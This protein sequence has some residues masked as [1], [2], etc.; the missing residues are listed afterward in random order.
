MHYQFVR[1]L[2]QQLLDLNLDVV[3]LII[4]LATFVRHDG[5]G[6]HGTR[7]S[8]RTTKS[9]LGRNKHVGNILILAEEGDMEND[10]EGLRIGSHHD[11]RSLSTVQGLRS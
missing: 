3:D 7:H 4:Q 6:D 5:A 2:N 11:K 8:T 9:N 1:F 10:F